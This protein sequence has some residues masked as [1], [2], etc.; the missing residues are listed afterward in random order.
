MRKFDVDAALRA[1]VEGTGGATGRAFFDALV[2]SLAKT[3]GI[4]GAWV[5]R[6]HPRECR[7]K[8]LAFWLRGQFIHD[9][10]YIVTDTPCEA[11][12]RDKQT[13]HYEDNVAGLFPQD[14]MLVQENAVSFMGMPLISNSGAVLGHLAVFDDKPMP[15]DKRALALY[16]IFANRA[17]AELER[18]NAET[19]LRERETKLSRLIDSTRDA[20]IELDPQL[21][22]TL[23]NPAA[24]R[25][26]AIERNQF[27]GRNFMAFVP[28]A[29]RIRLLNQ[30]AEIDSQTGEQRSAWIPGSLEICRG[31]G[32][33][34][35]AEATLSRYDMEG[36]A[37]H[38]V[39]LRSVDDRLEAE[40]KI[41]SLMVESEYLRSEIRELL[42]VDE[43]IGNSPKFSAVLQDVGKVAETDA[44][45]LILG[46]TGTGKELIARA[47]HANSRRADKPLIKVN[48]A[49]IP[50]NLIESEFFG[51]ERGAFTGAT[52][53]RDGRFALA[54]GGTIFLDEV[55]ELPIEL[56][57][58]LLRVLQEGEFEPLGSSTTRQIDVRVIAA[59]NRD[60][61]A[62]V[63]KGNFR[64]DLYY[65]LNVFP[66]VVPPLR[67][68]GDD[69]IM[70][71][72]KFIERFA[73]QTGKQGIKLTDHCKQL[74][75]SYRW[76]GNVRELENIIERA[77]IASDGTRL[78][79]MRALPT[80]D[81]P[82]VASSAALD[83]S[84]VYT[85]EQMVELEKRNILAALNATGWRVAGDQ[86]A[87]QLLGMSPSTLSS[88][89]KSLGIS[90]PGK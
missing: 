2:Q 43:M 70:I 44:T 63:R 71:A 83:I 57:S 54:D 30:I 52:Q 65:R 39:L 50:A 53:R 90:R 37:Y 20:I 41:Q 18:L 19:Q 58:K 33:T 10:D 78:N 81:S 55:S 87:A 49:A 14:S 62:E 88:R 31:D 86:G 67:K 26:F 28:E 15:P 40:R 3:L 47:I 7:L 25:T 69:V 85:A 24:Q 9:F 84:T 34:F 51:H 80:A 72:E 45:T 16:R 59:T 89:M 42:K 74:L 32:S 29:D 11:V 77:V 22:V 23:I 8:A 64:A 48:C 27:I 76:P 60:L 61:E 79:L 21:N 17:T 56:Q 36:E 6:Y 68:R 1:V 82:L 66:I 35:Q 38:I 73:R 5:T 75:R 46:E 4:M 13:V 12:I